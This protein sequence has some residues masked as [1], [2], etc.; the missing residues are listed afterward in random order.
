MIAVTTPMK[1]QFTAPKELALKTHSDA[2]IT[3]ASQ[4]RGIVM[5]VNSS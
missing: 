4:P 5:E 1:T 3:D 2:Q